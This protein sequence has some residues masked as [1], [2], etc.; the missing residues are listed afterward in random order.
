MSHNHSLSSSVRVFISATA[1]LL[2]TGCAGIGLPQPPWVEAVAGDGPGDAKRI[3]NEPLAVRN[4][5]KSERGNPPVYRVFGETYRVLDSAENFK[6]WGV[7]SW[8]G[9]K[10]HG[11]ETSSGEIYD[12]HQMTAAHKHLPI[13]TFATVTRVDTGK[14]IVVKINDRG[15]FVGDRVIDLSYAAAMELDMVDSG[16]AD[17]YIEALTTHHVT[18]PILTEPLDYSSD[19]QTA[20]LAAEP[21]DVGFQES[22]SSDLFIQVGAFSRAPNAER[23][24]SKVRKAVDLPVAID[25]DKNRR[26]HFVRVG[27]MPN[28][29]LLEDALDS[30]SLAGIESFTFV[31]SN[32]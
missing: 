18:N 27:P 7:A 5:P 6:E 21:D 26:L 9:K 31:T 19:Q 12:M 22:V 8:Y 28:E 25:H 30:L 23:M 29:M 2:L 32:P 10:F 17:V 16:K 11:R 4:L 14:S 1:L 20:M 13:P 3:Q 15:P 24:V